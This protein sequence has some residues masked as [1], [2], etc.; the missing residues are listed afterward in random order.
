MKT[1]T[2]LFTLF[3]SFAGFSQKIKIK[4]GQVSV[5]GVDMLYVK[6][7][8]AMTTEVSYYFIENDEEFLFTT[9]LEYTDPSKVSSGNPEG[10]V[11]YIEMNFI[12]LNKTLWKASP[13]IPHKSTLKLAATKK[14]SPI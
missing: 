7:D 1:A 14:G 6:P 8:G 12:G 9:Y 10:K 2:I 5:D 3:L 13:V 4:K 11:R